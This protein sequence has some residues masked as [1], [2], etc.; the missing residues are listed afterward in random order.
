MRK[1]LTIWMLLLGFSLPGLARQ[2]PFAAH[3]EARI[4]AAIG[5]SAPADAG[6]GRDSDRFVYFCQGKPYPVIIEYRNGFVD[7]I[8][9]DIFGH[10]LKEGNRL[11]CDFVERYFLETLL[12]RCAPDPGYGFKPAGVSLS[13]NWEEVVEKGRDGLSFSCWY[14]EGSG[15]RMDLFYEADLPVCSL[16]F[17]TKLKVLTGKDKDELENAFL[18][19]VCADRPPRERSVP[20][21]LKRVDRNLYVSENGFWQIEPAQYTAWFTKAGSAY[22]PLCESAHPAESVLTLLTGYVR[23]RD[24]SV[25]ATFHQY[26]YKQREVVIPLTR[27]LDQ[28]LEDGCTPYAGLESLKGSTVVATLFLVNG[29]L[30]YCH[31]FRFTLD[32]ALLDRRSG[33]LQAKAYLFT[34][35]NHPHR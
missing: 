3:R 12:D 21:N 5:W 20:G 31:T 27:L 25:K 2:A 11:A 14:A 23:D 28:C 15:A 8:G 16:S 24:Y 13:G 6:Q 9:L 29:Q 17:P 22:Q 26:G 35:F 1:T 33:V 7:H 32:T 30:G 34:P 4:A 19:D 18:R 10:D